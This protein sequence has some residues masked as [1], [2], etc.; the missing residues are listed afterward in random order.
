MIEDAE[1]LVSDVDAQTRPNKVIV[2]ATF[3]SAVGEYSQPFTFQTVAQ[4]T[5][6]FTQAVNNPESEFAKSPADYTLFALGVFDLDN[7]VFSNYQAKQNLGLALDFV[8]QHE[9]PGQLDFVGGSSASPNED[10]SA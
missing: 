2:F 1:K 3:D 7:G 8:R 10:A 9:H 4:C 6:S 5:R